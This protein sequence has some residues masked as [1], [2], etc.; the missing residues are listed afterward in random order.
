MG[1]GM[2]DAR[3]GWEVDDEVSSCSQGGEHTHGPTRACLASRVHSRKVVADS[4]VESEF[5]RPQTEGGRAN[6]CSA[7][8]PCSISSL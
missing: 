2:W 8:L 6:L 1:R 4:G 5:S 7:P 3:K